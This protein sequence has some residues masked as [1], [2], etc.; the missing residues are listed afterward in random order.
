MPDMSDTADTRPYAIAE[1]IAPTVR[2]VLARNPSHFTYTGTQSYIVGTG[3]E[4]G[5]AS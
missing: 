2:R 1:Q 5:R 3:R 4:R